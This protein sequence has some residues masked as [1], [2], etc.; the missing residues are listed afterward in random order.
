MAGTIPV[1]RLSN[2]NQGGAPN[3]R[4]VTSLTDRQTMLDKGYTAEGAG[5]GVGWC[6]PG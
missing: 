1:Y 4:F 6:A 3:H 5:I 2:N